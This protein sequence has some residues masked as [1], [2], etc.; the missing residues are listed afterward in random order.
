MSSRVVVI[1]ILGVGDIDSDNASE[2]TTYGNVK[3]EGTVVSLAN[4]L[5]SEIQVFGTL[6]SDSTTSFTVLSTAYT[7]RLLMS[8][9]K[10]EVRDVGAYRNQPLRLAGY[11][12]A[13]PGVVTLPFVSASMVV[14]GYYRI[15]NTVFKILTVS[16]TM[17][18]L[19][20]WGC[21]PVPIAMAK[22]SEDT[23]IGAKVYDLN[24]DNP[25]GGCEQLPVI[26]T[27]QETDGSNV[28]TIFRGY[29]SK[30]SNDTS[31]GQQ[32]LIRVDCSSM[33]AYLKQSPFVPAW[34]TVTTGT[35]T[36]TGDEFTQSEL[37][38]LVGG[39]YKTF[40]N[41]KEFGPIYDDAA[42]ETAATVSKLWQI[43]EGDTGGI[44][45]RES[46]TFGDVGISSIY[47]ITFNETATI[48]DNGFRMSFTKGYYLNGDFGPK[49]ELSV[50]QV[51]D[52][53]GY[54]RP[55]WESQ[56]L[57]QKP[58]IRGE[59]CVES[60]NYASCII[61]LLLGCYHA[62]ITLA[63]GARSCTESAWL[64]YDYSSIDDIIDQ[65]SLFALTTGLNN[66]DIVAV[67]FLA[68][69]P[70][71]VTLLP[72]EP[73]SA[74]TVADVLDNILKRLGGYMVYDQGKFWF[75]S[76]AGKRQTPATVTDSALSDPAIKLTFDRGLS[77]MRVNAAYGDY[78][79]EFIKYDVPYNNADLSTANLG[80]EM[81]ISHWQ[82]PFKA[83]DDPSWGY[84]RMVANAFG[85]IMR[86]SQSAA[87]VDLSLRD[88]EVDL[89]IGQEVAVT[90]QY[91]VNSEGEMGVQALTGY[92]LK[93]ARSWATPTTAY[94]II[95]PGYLSPSNKVSVW[96][97][98]ARVDDVPG[99]DL[100]QVD[101]NSFTA[102]TDIA[103]PGAP[104][105]DAEAFQ[106]THDLIGNWYDVQLLDQ[107]GTLKYQGALVGVTGNFLNLP[108]FD[109]Y[110]GQ[111]DIIVLAASTQFTSTQLDL[112]YDVF[113]A[114]NAGQVDG[115]TDYARKWVP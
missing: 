75:G 99:G 55:S 70:G 57:A 93:A 54:R 1:R 98:S 24:N 4:Q 31:A 74:K 20:V 28:R 19:R 12:M 21:A 115:S 90:S 97:C 37:T 46:F 114:N 27:T 58:S 68:Q 49:L 63:S 89:Q 9:G 53:F 72:Y 8:R 73:A 82:I 78:G 14:G 66:P 36:T 2:F 22:E 77:I 38:F 26:I 59:N 92:V 64:P 69:E 61:D 87:R 81:S 43:R 102:T 42:P 103:S 52:A 112:I 32:N 101:A 76:W 67:G 107:Y 30:V 7:R 83:P 40:W 88:S 80:K 84:T 45:I 11:I 95:L 85:L 10:V 105:T 15:Q 17:T 16:P 6:G 47:N 39:A 33:M 106:L 65:A 51:T 35:V 109:I 25:L 50:S 60:N 62:D 94:T 86:Y 41:I 44:G 23:L 5:S 91:L 56:L 104:A 100:I 96:S 110:A 79:T 3:A 29:V 48:V 111:G 18:A 108:G 71:F 34:G 13:T 113:Q